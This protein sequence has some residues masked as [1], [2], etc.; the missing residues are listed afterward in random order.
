MDYTFEKG[1]AADI[2][3]VMANILDVRTNGVT[4]WDEE[5]PAREHIEE[6]AREGALYVL[7][8]ADGSVAGSIVMYVDDVS[9]EEDTAGAGW[10]KAEK[11]ASLFRLCVKTK[12]QG[13]GIGARMVQSAMDAARAEGCDA[14]RLLASV[15]NGTANRLYERLGFIQKGR[16]CVYEGWFNAYEKAL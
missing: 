15:E 8:A 9:F 2:D 14:V 7:R 5:Y 16:V 3:A 13:Q 10:S 1:A 6:D 4:D 12:L 11:S